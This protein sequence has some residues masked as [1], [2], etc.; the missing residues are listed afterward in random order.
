MNTKR[1]AALPI[2]ILFVSALAVVFT[3]YSQSLRLDESQ[4]IWV[5]TKSVGEILN[6]VG[7]DVHVPLYFL[8]LHFWVQIFG[9]DVFISRL[10]SLMFFILSIFVIY[11]LASEVS[12][13]RLAILTIALFSLSPFIIW[14]AAETRMY[15]LFI[16]ISTLQSLSFIIFFKSGGKK[17]KTALFIT[18]LL[19]FFTHYFFVF[20]LFTQTIFLFAKYIPS[21]FQ[22]KFKPNLALRKVILKFFLVSGSAFVLFIPW[23]IY[24]FKLGSI[25]NTQPLIPQPSTYN[26]FQTFINFLF[27]FQSQDI[28]S[29][30]VSLWP[31][32]IIIMF[33]IFTKRAESRPRLLDYFILLTILPVILAFIISIIFKPLFLS[34]YLIFVT[35]SLFLILA[36]IILTL[37]KK[38]VIIGVFFALLSL[39]ALIYQNISAYSPIKEDYR[40]VANY[41][42]Q[43]V[44]SKDIIVISS[45]FTIYPI[46]YYYK[47]S[48][49]IDTLP[50]WDR[51]T[52]GAIPPFSKEKLVSQ[53]DNYKTQ[54]IRIFVVL[55]YDQ[56]YEKDIREYFDKST[57]LL[58]KR[59]F[60]P[61]LEVRVY[62][63][64]YDVDLP[65]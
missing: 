62:R 48:A 44:T 58:D 10:L 1:P 33:L 55:S 45:P 50:S 9:T 63:L 46:E 57:L 17:G 12:D 13:N 5:A 36:W 18:S 26:I 32:S 47:G 53:V 7:Q 22:K 28:Q 39:A 14:Y 35:P 30:L 31:L 59:R 40:Q 15:T 56:G 42:N 51:F 38:K 25:S 54:N 43:N 49:S 52:K 11:K 20:Q 64:R 60:S 4:S 65:S 2:L 21:A 19:G 27:G 61:G 6:F 16:L 29:T 34:R 3:L 8:L 37:I 24:V 23:I 41:L